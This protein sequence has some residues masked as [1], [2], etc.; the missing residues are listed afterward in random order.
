MWNKIESQEVIA[1]KAKVKDLNNQLADA[2]VKN[3]NMSIE[4]PRTSVIVYL[5]NEKVLRIYDADDYVMLE[6]FALIYKNK[7]IVA[8]VRVE[9]ITAI[10]INTISIGEPVSVEKLQGGRHDERATNRV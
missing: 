8:S 7:E 6:A 5:K 2:V 9:E 3:M 10:S 4:K 1:L